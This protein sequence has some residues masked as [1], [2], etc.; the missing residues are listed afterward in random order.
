[1]VV[2]DKKPIHVLATPAPDQPIRFALSA[3]LLRLLSGTKVGAIEIEPGEISPEA[4]SRRIGA[5]LPDSGRLSLNPSFILADT[6]FAHY[7]S[8]MMSLRT[9]ACA[10]NWKVLFHAG[11]S[12]QSG[13]S[14]IPGWRQGDEGRTISG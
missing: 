1:M 12:F 8:I 9:P 11:A 3:P 2:Q 10:V 7:R 14:Q 5:R 4:A 13:S 6:L